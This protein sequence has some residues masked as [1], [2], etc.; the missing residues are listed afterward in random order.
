MGAV[1]RMLAVKTKGGPLSA[2]AADG[3][4][5]NTPDPFFVIGPDRSGTTAIAQCLGA[6]PVRVDRALARLRRVVRSSAPGRRVLAADAIAWQGG[7]AVVCVIPPGASHCQATMQ[8][9]NA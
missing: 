1:R 8:Y 6:H 5:M 2:E 9:E 3:A 4:A 7:R